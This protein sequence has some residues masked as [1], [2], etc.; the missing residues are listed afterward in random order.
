MRRVVRLKQHR[1]GTDDFLVPPD[2]YL[3]KTDGSLEQRPYRRRTTQDGF[4]D[5]G[6]E[7]DPDKPTIFLV[8]GSFVEGMYCDEDAR[9][10]AVAMRLL[11]ANVVNAGYSGMTA[12]QQLT[13]ISSKLV[14]LAKQNDAICIF[15]PMSDVSVLRTPGSYWTSGKLYTPIQP[16]HGSV[17]F[18]SLNHLRVLLDAS[19]SISRGM[20]LK[21]AVVASPYRKTNFDSDAWVRRLYRQNKEAHQTSQ[22]M[23][24]EI[25]Q[26]VK[27]TARSTQVPA[28]DLHSLLAQ[29]DELFYDELH[30][31]SMGHAE[32]GRLL[33]DFLAVHLDISKLDTSA[34]PNSSASALG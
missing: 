1:A 11:D 31:N 5:T 20:G 4:L 17:L 28:L 29:R 7:I 22:I 21:T 24:D 13:V 34:S 12:L 8:G 33:A 27:A 19:I 32:V 26:T 18:P 16:P 6:L 2:K 30:L 25:S 10:P 3:A 23:G 15:N 14:G 9:F